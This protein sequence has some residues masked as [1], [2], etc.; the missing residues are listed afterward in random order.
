MN[1]LITLIVFAIAQMY[2]MFWLADYWSEP[3]H[4]W[5]VPT[6]FVLSGIGIYRLVVLMI[7]IDKIIATK[8]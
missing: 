4:W 7:L 6:W 3:D 2:F 1:R 5:E 8:P